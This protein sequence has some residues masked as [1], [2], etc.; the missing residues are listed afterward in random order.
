MP[1]GMSWCCSKC[2]IVAPNTVAPNV[3]P[4]VTVSKINLL[5]GSTDLLPFLTVRRA[6]KAEKRDSHAKKIILSFLPRFP[7]LS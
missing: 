7:K 1:P 2:G 5:E 6:K 3:A 4:N